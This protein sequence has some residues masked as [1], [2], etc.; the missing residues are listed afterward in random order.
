[1]ETMQSVGLGVAYVILGVVVLL[2][3][4]IINDL[5]TP[6]RL[7]EELTGKDNPAFG[8]VLAGYF[9][10][11]VIIFLGAVIGPDPDELV[12]LGAIARMIGIDFAYAVGGIIA[13]NIG[14]WVVDRLVLYKFS[15]A[16]EVIVDRNMGTGAVECGCMI[17]TAL[18]IAGAIHGEGGGPLSA[19][20]FF[21]LGQLVLVLFGLF[22][23]WITKYDIH[24]EIER[25]N[26]AAGVALG[27]SM[28]AIGIIVLKASAGDLEGWSDKLTWFAIY[29][30]LGALLLMLLRKVTDALFLPGTTIQREIAVDRNVNAALIEGVIAIGISAIFFFVV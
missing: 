8:L 19:L 24:A 6:Y 20:A 4:K 12:S 5:T 25:D 15:T 22:Y 17:A 10:G 1:M 29:V 18:I 9:A 23:Q 14:R 16:K 26:V 21:L 30:V 2:L 7:D 28:V 11:V 3:A 27:M 13:L